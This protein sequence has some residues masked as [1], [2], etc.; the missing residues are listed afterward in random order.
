MEGS[1]WQAR[2]GESRGIPSPALDGVIMTI[3]YDYMDKLMDRYGVA[4]FKARCLHIIEEVA[5]TGKEVQ[6]SK[7]GRPAVRILPALVAESRPA[8]GYLKGMGRWEDGI[9]GTGEAWDAQGE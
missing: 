1:S 7:R 4:E 6:V 2:G 8:Y 9:L 5:K 3:Y